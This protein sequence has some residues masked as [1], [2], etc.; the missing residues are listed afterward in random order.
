M[1][2]CIACGRSTG[3]RP[4]FAGL[5]RCN[6]CG[7][8]THRTSDRFDASALYGAQY[9]RGEEYPDYLGQ[10]RALRRS[11]QRHLSQM[12]KYGKLDGALLEVGCAYGFFL[13]EA[14]ARFKKVVGV[15]VAKDA[16]EHASGTLGLDA[17]QGDL[18]QLDLADRFEVI[19]LWDTVEHLPRPDATLERAR[20]LLSER[21]LL[22]LTTGD[23]TSLNARLRGA[24]WRQ[25]HPP[26]HLHYF[27]RAT[28]ARLLKRVGL[29]VV[30]I[31]TAAYYHTL[32]NVLGSLGLRKGWLGR[33][34]RSA[35]ASIG[36]ELGSKFGFWVDLGDIM[37]VAARAV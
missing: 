24:R 34:A 16:I 11:M 25:I 2:A 27:S 33:I 9:F 6:E 14:R 29:E 28:I 8:I 5:D 32:F 15:D 17:R 4:T 19:C 3:F 18:L 10:E 22:F 7:F 31:E 21:G 1:S 12:S 23:V 26:T 36:Q 37:F 30:G 20:S 35:G 13:D